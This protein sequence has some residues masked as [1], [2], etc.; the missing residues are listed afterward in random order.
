[1]V[2]AGV[3]D[4]AT[5]EALVAALAN[6]GKAN[7]RRRSL[8]TG[9]VRCGACG[10]QMGRDGRSWR[11]R[12]SNTYPKAFGHVQIR[13]AGLEAL[14]EKMVIDLLSS[15]SKLARA[16]SHHEPERTD[17]A[18]LDMAAAEAKLAELDEML[19]AGE[20]SRVSYLRALKKPEA[21]LE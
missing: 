4:R 9:L 12:P 19:G 18:A 7:P 21:K 3:I 17:D 14:I 10:S 2:W 16:M 8:L 5:H 13:A 1:A 11:C 6:N 20:L 15:S